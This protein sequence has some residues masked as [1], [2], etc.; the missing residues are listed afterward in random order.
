MVDPQETA[1]TDP[2]LSV[3]VIGMAGRFPGAD[4]VAEFWAN[5][6]AGRES[7]T[8]VDDESYL[9]AGG[10]PAALDDPYLVRAVNEVAGMDQFDAA[11]FGYGPADAELIDPQQ[12]LFL[13]CAHHAFESSGY[14]P[15]AYPGAVGVYAGAA[16]SRYYTANLA[17]WYAGQPNSIEQMAAAS[18]NAPGTLPTRVSYLFNLTGPSVSVQTACSTS[19][20]AV[21]L[22]CQDLL[23]YRC[24]L[25]LAGGV[26]VNPQARLGYRHVQDGPYSPDGHVRAFDADA[27]GMM[28]GDGVGAVV[29]KRLDEAIADGD[30]IRAVILGSAVNNDGNRKVGFSAPSTVGQAE[31]IVAAQLAAGVT[32]DSIDYV[33]THGTATPVGDPI[34]IAALATAFARGPG[35]TNSCAIG[36]VKTNI[37]HLDAAAGIA[38]LIKTVL[39][40]ENQAIPASLN[41]NR[42]NPLLDLAAGPFHVCTELTAWTARPER[43]RRAG[44]SS[45]GIG[46]TNVHV[47]LE[48]AP[49]VERT[50]P[51]PTWY[52]L[53]LS[54]RTPASLDALAADLARHIAD[55]PDPNLADIA[56]TLQTG[57]ISLPLRRTV[58]CESAKDAAELLSLPVPAPTA[59]PAEPRIG[60]LFPGGGSH[61]DGMGR[62][63]YAAEPVFRRFMDASAEILWPVLGF[64][65]LAVL[66]GD[67]SVEAPVTDGGGHTGRLDGVRTGTRPAALPALAAT[68]HALARMLEGYG[69]RPSVLLGH[70]LGEY[71]AACVAGVL[72]LE[73]ML[74]LVTE[75]ERIFSEVDGTTLSVMASEHELRPL[76]TPGLGVAAVNADNVCT[77]S[78][79]TDEI[80]GLE[81][82]LAGLHIDHHR[83]RISFPVHCAL[84]EPKLDAFRALLRTVELHEPRLP[85]VS[86]VTGTWITPA[87][88]TDPEYWVRHS[89]ATVRFADGLDCLA[90][91]AGTVLVEVG[92]GTGL[93]KLALM[94]LGAD[95][96]CVPSL[97]HAY[98]QQSD[99]RFHLDTLGRLWQAGI[100]VDYTALHHTGR[101]RTPLP[102]YRFDRRRYWIDPPAGATGI[103]ARP[104][105]HSSTQDSPIPVA[106]ATTTPRGDATMRRPALATPYVPA[107]TAEER[108]VAEV[109]ADVLG[110]DRVGVH[111]NFFDLGGESLQMMRL[112]ARVRDAIHANLSVRRLYLAQRL[113]VAGFLAE[114][115][116]LRA[117][118][119]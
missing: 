11:F 46:G 71:S 41:F 108:L 107:R 42:A 21:H 110:V 31:V 106:T 94:R 98:A 9:A 92:P 16:F 22:A 70:S 72:T 80:V 50:D 12:R 75:R 109:W 30:P 27:A 64:D 45:F 7:L 78:G 10:N 62:G 6:A 19:L 91:A 74:R 118:Q 32:A 116:E 53:P 8:R 15:A 60:F 13:E 65:L 69:V 103:P 2:A 77:V 81:A 1:S 49:T 5:L 104:T 4:S 73:D 90:G 29:L 105:P 26:S 112:V 82:V 38:G 97:R 66:Y 17:P 56:Y 117:G 76:L 84:L 54:A 111:D 23:T 52:L 86:N 34:E 47:V 51:E 102:G 58:V 115:D 63:L 93:G 28:Q 43:P 79:V 119:P 68:E 67:E 3:A 85:Y 39:A 113:T 59:A 83:L 18:G 89:V 95:Q 40:L 55:D 88:A 99:T 61:Y 37:G 35:R 24:D 48:Q 25:A 57:R 101:R 33:E 14:V 36:S 87:Q 20:V 100:P 96:P 114:A 44:V